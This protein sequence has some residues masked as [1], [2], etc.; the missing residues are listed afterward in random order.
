MQRTLTLKPTHELY[1][2]VGWPADDGDLCVV[3]GTAVV[4]RLLRVNAGPAAGAWS[5]SITQTEIALRVMPSHGRAESLDDARAVLAQIFAD[6]P[7][8]L[9]DRVVRAAP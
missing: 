4:G 8:A 7:A 9:L 3:L 2:R 6:Q 1:P 5:W